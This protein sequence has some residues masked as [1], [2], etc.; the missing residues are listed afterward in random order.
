MQI[1]IGKIYKYIEKDDSIVYIEVQ[2]P[3]YDFQKS[4]ENKVYVC[5]RTPYSTS[6]FCQIET[7]GFIDVKLLLPL[8]N[9]KDKEMLKRIKELEEKQ[10]LIS[11]RFCAYKLPNGLIHVQNYIIGRSG[12][13]HVHDRASFEKWKKDIEPETLTISEAETCNCGLSCSG[14][15]KEYDGKIWHNDRFEG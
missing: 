2:E 4:T 13:H 6:L 11:M 10:R 3:K 12:Q 5:T 14:D 1:E 7:C 9:K 15:V 8:D